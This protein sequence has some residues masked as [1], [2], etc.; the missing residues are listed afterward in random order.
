MINMAFTIEST[1]NG[2]GIVIEDGIASGTLTTGQLVALTKGA[3]KPTATSVAVTAVPDA[4]VVKGGL[5]TTAITFARLFR[6]DVLKCNVLAADGSTALSAGENTSHIALVGSQ[7]QRLGTGALSLDGVT[8]AGG[9]MELLSY[10]S[11]RREARVTI[12]P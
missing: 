4:V 5:T 10:D 3:G 8:E 12:K 1:Y 6:G 7:A 2:R 9:K 11:A